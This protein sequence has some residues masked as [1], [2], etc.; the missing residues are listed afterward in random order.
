M[1]KKSRDESKDNLSVSISSR[2]SDVFCSC[3]SRCA[4][5]I[6]VDALNIPCCD[7]ISMST[8]LSQEACCP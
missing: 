8:E 1:T 5:V 6:G 4:L 3:I 7:G 2:E